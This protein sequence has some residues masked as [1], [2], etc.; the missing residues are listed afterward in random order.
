MEAPAIHAAPIAAPH[1][2]ITRSCSDRPSSAAHAHPHHPPPSTTGALLP[3]ARFWGFCLSFGWA[4]LVQQWAF[5]AI[6][7]I[8][9]GESHFYT[10]W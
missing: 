6:F 8:V 10:Q 7:L 2:H 3:Q 5:G 9:E 1:H 4:S